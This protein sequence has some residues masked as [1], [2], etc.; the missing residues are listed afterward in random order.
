MICLCS[1]CDEE[2]DWSQNTERQSPPTECI[3]LKAITIECNLCPQTFPADDDL[4]LLRTARH[5]EGRHGP[6]GTK[7]KTRGTVKWHAFTKQDYEAMQND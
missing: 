1:Y 2:N 7:N 5:E 6:K 3:G 4:L